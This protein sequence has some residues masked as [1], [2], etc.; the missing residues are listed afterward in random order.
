[1]TL[2]LSTWQPETEELMQAVELN[3]IE[4][5]LLTG[6]IALVAHGGRVNTEISF[7]SWR[8]TGERLEYHPERG[9]GPIGGVI[10]SQAGGTLKVGVQMVPLSILGQQIPD[11]LSVHM[12]AKRTEG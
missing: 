7:G 1:M 11:G 3:G 4:S 9:F 8:I 10:Y 5:E 2:Q 12:E 6:N